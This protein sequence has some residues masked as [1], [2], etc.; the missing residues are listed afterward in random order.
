MLARARSAAVVA[1]ALAGTALA[2]TAF[3][4]AAHADSQPLLRV[5][6]GTPAPSGPLTRGG[7]TET[8]ELT[9]E[10]PG[11]K[12]R[13][14][15]PWLLLD[16]DGPSPLQTADITYRVEPVNAPATAATVGHQDGGWQ[17]MFHPASGNAGD[18]FD[19]PAGSKLTW[20][21]TVGLTKSYPTIN[22]GF[23]LTAGSVQRELERP[24]SLDFTVAPNDKPGTFRTWIEKTGGC[25]GLPETQCQSL[26]VHYEVGDHGS[27]DHPLLTQ[28]FAGYAG[29]HAKNPDLVVQ[30]K[31]DG[32]WKVMKG[33][34]RTVN[35]PAIAKGL[36]ADSGRRTLSLRVKLGDST[37]ITRLT[38]VLLQTETRLDAG[39]NGVF[40]GAGDTEIV[41]GPVRATPAPSTSPSGTPSTTPSTSPTVTPTTSSSAPAPAAPTSPATPA[42]ARNGSVDGS[43]A[44]TG[45]GSTMPLYVGAAL[46][47]LGGSV[48]IA[49]RRRRAHR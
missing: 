46:L 20:K 17:G 1:T 34:D 43:L 16:R 24:D 4:P 14:Y 48:W 5:E 19:V 12:A 32:R 10:N 9:V 42:A 27:F 3:V 49:A 23:K 41:L 7:A 8:F 37:G 2:G 30:A 44:E 31:V 6:L 39:N 40:G 45:S 11:T 15:H 36:D 33:D 25:E 29:I 28:L 18:G 35:L 21:V 26:D 22:G 38:R 13:A 47:A